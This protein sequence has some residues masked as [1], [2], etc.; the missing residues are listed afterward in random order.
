VYRRAETAVRCVKI[1]Y[2][3]QHVSD[4]VIKLEY[5]ADVAC[6]TPQAVYETDSPTHTVPADITLIVDVN[7][8]R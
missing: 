2:M 3:P 7:P 6:R 8:K 4:T 5:T 1:I